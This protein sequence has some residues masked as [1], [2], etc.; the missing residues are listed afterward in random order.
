M[1]ECRGDA[2][3]LNNLERN[4]VLT[5]WKVWVLVNILCAELP[6]TIPKLIPLNL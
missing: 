2:S 1:V 6:C 5:Y 3:E 4:R